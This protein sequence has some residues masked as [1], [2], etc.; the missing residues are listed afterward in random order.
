[1]VLL[2]SWIR[3]FTYTWGLFLEGSEK[4]SLYS[5][6]RNMNRGSLHIKRFRRMHLSVFRYRLTKNGFACTKCFS[7]ASE[8]LAWQEAPYVG[9]GRVEDTSE[10]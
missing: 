4:F 10:S 3:L 2:C 9:E 6:I 7:W 5:H 8:K 1:M